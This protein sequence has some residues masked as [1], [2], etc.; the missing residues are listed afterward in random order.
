[1]SHSA[2]KFRRGNLWCFAEFLHEKG[3]SLNSVE[4]P[5]SHC[6]EKIRRRTF[7]CFE[8]IL[9]SKVFKQRKGEASRFCRNFFYFTG[10]KKLRLGTIL[11]FKK[12]LVAKNFYG[13]KG[14]LTIFRQ[15]AFVSQ[16]RNENLCKGTLLFSR[17]F[18]IS[19]NFMRK[20]RISRFSIEKLVS[21]S[22]NKVCRE[23]I[24]CFTKFLVSKNLMDMVGG[25]GGSITIFFQ[26]FFCLTLPKN[27]VKERFRVSLISGIEKFYA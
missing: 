21:H 2:E 23:T 4:N 10:P 20:R 8:K 18:R 7:L 6:S 19:K 25:G 1:M 27:F 15:K 24:L 5:L 14:G 11:S 22:T 9:V 3:L 26:K 12:V 16:Y 13:Y 17:K